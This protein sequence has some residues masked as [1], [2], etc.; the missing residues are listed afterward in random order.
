MYFSW[1]VLREQSSLYIIRSI[2]RHAHWKANRRWSWQFFLHAKNNSSAKSIFKSKV[3]KMS[4]LVSTVPT[5]F[6]A[7]LSEL[8]LLIVTATKPSYVPTPPLLSSP[9]VTSGWVSPNKFYLQTWNHS[10]ALCFPLWTAKLP[11]PLS[12]MLIGH[13]RPD[14]MDRICFTCDTGSLWTVP[15]IILNDAWYWVRAVMY[16]TVRIQ[17]LFPVLHIFSPVLFS[18]KI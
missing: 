5:L 7:K 15:V 18:L 4:N 14:F 8:L 13:L 9:V 1:L 17:Y 10:A 12:G 11:G 6:P 2:Y 16:S 3:Q